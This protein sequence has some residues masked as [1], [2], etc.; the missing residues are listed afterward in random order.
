MPLGLYAL[1]AI[2]GGLL[3][4]DLWPLLGNWLQSQSVDAPTWSP[5]LFGYR[6][7]LLAAVIGG[8]RILYNSL[9]SLFE[10]RIG[11]D[12]ALAIACLAAIV[13]K[14]ELVA[15][16]VVFI[17][18]AGE[19]LEA[20]TFART[21][22]AL[23]S[24]AELFPQRCWVLRD[25][26]EVRTFTADLQVGDRIVVKP[27]GRIPADGRVLDG[28]SAVDASALTGESLPLD[29]NPGDEVLAGSIVVDGSLTI[30]AKKI[31]KQTVAGQVIELTAAALK[32]K[33][34]LQRQADRLA[35]Y[36]LPAVL[37]LALLTFFANLLFQMSGTP[38]LGVPKPGWDAAMRVASYPALAVL[39]VAC[40]CALILATPAAVIAALGRLAGTGVLIK[41]GSALER[42]AGVT[43]FAFDKTGTLTEGKLE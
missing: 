27:G 14:E 35:K 7:A 28:R 10:G 37:V 11:A 34:P 17:G 36:F 1:T 2:V 20:Y 23:G 24:L 15:A 38:A 31:A 5:L 19:C 41:G 13:L 29:K 22:R 39:V 26:Q 43:A 32:D 18:L 25:G 3:A 30:Q 21:R 6:F 40:P 16:E 42:L 8:A 12:L 4:A 9:E 33:A